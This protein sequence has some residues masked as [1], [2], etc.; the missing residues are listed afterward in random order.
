MSST[1]E[2]ANRKIIEKI[3]YVKLVIEQLQHVTEILKSRDIQYENI[4]SSKFLHL[5]LINDEFAELE[6]QY[7]LAII[8]ILTSYYGKRSNIKYHEENNTREFNQIINSDNFIP[9]IEEYLDKSEYILGILVD[10]Y[11]KQSKVVRESP[12]GKKITRKRGHP[13]SLVVADP[14]YPIIERVK[15]QISIARSISITMEVFKSDY[16]S[17]ASCGH[18]MTILPTTSEMVC[19]NEHC[20]E[21]KTLHGTASDEL[22][23]YGQD[24]GKPKHGKYDPSRHFR[25]WMERIQAKENKTFPQQHIDKIDKVIKRDQAEL[26]H[27]GDMRDILKECKLTKYNDHAPLLMKIFTGKSPPQ[28]SFT[29]LKRFSIKFNKI[30]DILEDIIDANSNNRPYY[31]YFIYKIDEAEMEKCIE[32]GDSE[33]YKELK[34]MLCYIHL[35]SDDTI[36]KNDALYKEICSRNNQNE[37]LPENML[38]YKSTERAYF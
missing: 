11:L 22:E 9:R 10:S 37:E 32:E 31:P 21:I 23:N 34:R 27:V 3:D 19:E 25:F 13:T 26:R 5:N 29:M 7:H 20:Q 2:S 8:H 36:K 4:L 28:L 18:R 1:I 30:I 24:S 17:C 6:N 33:T 12:G 35:Q 38:I 15:K 16:E 14:L